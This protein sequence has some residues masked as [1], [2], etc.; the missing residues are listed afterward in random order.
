MILWLL[1]LSY[2][3]RQMEQKVFRM[4]AELA[5]AIDD[6]RQLRID[7]VHLQEER[8]KELRASADFLAR[9]RYGAAMY[10]RVA[11]LPAPMDQR[12]MESLPVARRR[13]ADIASELERQF[14]ADLNKAEPAPAK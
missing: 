13:A 4:E 12:P 9:Q 6:S 11:E 10:D 3:F 7:M 5:A 1:R 14:M 2:R 8:A